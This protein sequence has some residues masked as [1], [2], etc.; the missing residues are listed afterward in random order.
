MKIT[1]LTF[2]K[3]LRKFFEFADYIGLDHLT[4]RSGLLHRKVGNYPGKKHLMPLCCWVMKKNME[5]SD[6]ILH[7]PEKGSGASLLIKYKVP[8]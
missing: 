8:R 1:K 5:K 2:E 7:Q 6:K 3:E 4:I